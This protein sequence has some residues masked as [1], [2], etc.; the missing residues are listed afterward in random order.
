MNSPVTYYDDAPK[1]RAIV[2]LAVVLALI[3]T[4]MIVSTYA[5][6]K[7]RLDER[8]AAALIEQRRVNDSTRDY[9]IIF[10]TTFWISSTVVT[11]SGALYLTSVFVTRTVQTLLDMRRPN[12]RLIE[13]GRK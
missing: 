6:D 9:R 13:R 1:W 2:V 7:M 3:A 10:L 4:V 5:I 12:V 11:S 8:A